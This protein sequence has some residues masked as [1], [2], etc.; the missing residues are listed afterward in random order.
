M[1]L[2]S[3]S[4]FFS[5]SVIMSW[6]NFLNF[7][8]GRGGT[9]GERE[10]RLVNINMTRR[11]GGLSAVLSLAANRK[12]NW[13]LKVRNG[14]WSFG[15]YGCAGVRAK[16]K[17]VL[18]NES[19]AKRGNAYSPLSGAVISVRVLKRFHH[20]S[21]VAIQRSHPQGADTW[22]GRPKTEHTAFHTP[23][24]EF[25]KASLPSFYCLNRF[26]DSPL[27]ATPP[28]AAIRMYLHYVAGHFP[29][30]KATY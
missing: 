11:M 10:N 25:M 22:F 4:V 1:Y 29:K 20:H 15:V 28:T 21:L 19:V 7:R 13:S 5:S 24:M 3:M 26:Y 18:L 23:S 9:W 2:T 30:Y 8:W 6:W 16:S 17:V 12:N 27:Q 14:E